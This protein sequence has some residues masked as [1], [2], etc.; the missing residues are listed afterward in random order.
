MPR[1]YD[2][3]DDSYHWFEYEDTDYVSHDHMERD[4]DEP[5]EPDYDPAEDYADTDMMDRE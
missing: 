4:W 2:N 1:E 5:Y 3:W